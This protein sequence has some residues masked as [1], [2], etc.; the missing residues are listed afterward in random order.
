MT[1]QQGGYRKPIPYADELSK[2]YWK[3]TQRGEILVQECKGCGHRQFYPRPMCLKC[4]STDLENRRCTGFGTI[5]SFTAT[6]QN[7]Q[8]GFREE[9]PYIFALIDLD[10]GPRMTANIVGCKPE[11]V[12]IGMRVTAVF[13]W[14]SPEIR[15]P[16]FRP[17]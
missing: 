2:A 16:R 14:I 10:E 6:Y 11:Q 15:L 3:G 1:T 12:K 7:Q 4:W 9:L 5:H 13:D 8:P 17:A